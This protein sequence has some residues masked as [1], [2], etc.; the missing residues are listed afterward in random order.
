M[1]QETDH[2][3]K[4]HAPDPEAVQAAVQVALAE[5]GNVEGP[6]LPVLHGIQERLGHVPAEAV[7]LV[8]KALNVSRAEVHGVI[9]YYHH[10]RQFQTGEHLVQICRA[11][12]CQARGAEALVEHAQQSLGCGLHETTADGAVT[13]EPTYCLGLC[14]IGPAVLIGK[15]ELHARVTPAGFDALIKEKRSGA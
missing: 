3:A 6:M 2:G 12:A 10:F 11:E 8:S 14:A 15:D 9:T 5:S 7:P 13:L 1:K 4:A